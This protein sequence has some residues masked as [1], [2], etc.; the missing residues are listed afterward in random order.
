[1]MMRKM[2]L[3]YFLLI[4]MPLGMMS[5]LFYHT[6]SELVEDKVTFAAEQSFEQSYTFLSYKIYN[7]KQSA[8]LLFKNPNLIRLLKSTQTDNLVKQMQDMY[9]LRN[10]L[11]TLQDGENITMA[12]L[13][14][15]SELLYSHENVNL[16][17]L[18]DGMKERWYQKMER[19]HL[20]NFWAP[21][22]YLGVEGEDDPPY[23]AYVKTIVDPDNYTNRLGSVHFEFSADDLTHLLAKASTTPNSVT[24]I[25][26]SYGDVVAA[27]NTG[28][29]SKYKISDYKLRELVANSDWSREHQH[30]QDVLVASKKID[31]T[32]WTMVTVLSLHEMMADS[33]RIRNYILLMLFF[34]GTGAYFIAFFFSKSITGRLTRLA[35][36]LRSVHTGNLT[37]MDAVQGKDEIDML[38][39]DYNYMLSMLNRFVQEKYEAGQALKS[40]ELRTLQAQI[41][42]HFLYNTL[43]LVNWLSWRNRGEQVSQVVEGLAQYYRI[44]LSGGR[45]VIT[46]EE[47]MQHV[48]LYFDIQNMRFSQNLTLIIDVSEEIRQL[49]TLKSILQPLVEN[50]ILHGILRRADKTGTVRIEGR[51]ENTS[52][53]ISVIDNGIGMLIE[54]EEG[55]PTPSHTGYGSRNVHDRIQLYFGLSYGLKY[56]SVVGEGTRVMVTLPIVEEP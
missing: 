47:E 26:N 13:Y 35:R 19:E 27:S 3:S 37:P 29:L 7:I 46:L 6:S 51:L 1:M 42:P 53:M 12:K 25:V 43:E 10:Y 22:A 31:N 16:F 40:A 2:L 44:S 23:L 8:N 4:L 15:R 20:N 55:Q 28:M 48:S 11:T 38:I 5:Y 21:A 56:Q 33:N 30:A 18:D 49:Y 36:R 45:D 17:S 34:L 52:V 50:A 39:G 24:Y 9:V 32:D 41:S 54:R 14:V